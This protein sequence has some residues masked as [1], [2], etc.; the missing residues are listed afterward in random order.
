MVIGRYKEWWDTK[1]KI[2]AFERSEMIYSNPPKS[3]Y[4]VV[5]SAHK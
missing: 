5:L 3:I 4:E 2:Q 1:V